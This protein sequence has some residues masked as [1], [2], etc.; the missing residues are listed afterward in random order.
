MLRRASASFE[1]PLI[2]E[3]LLDRCSPSSS[4][5]AQNALDYG[6]PP[7]TWVQRVFECK[8]LQLHDLISITDQSSVVV[9]IRTRQRELWFQAMLSLPRLENGKRRCITHEDQMEEGDHVGGERSVLG[10][11]LVKHA[12]SFSRCQLL[13]VSRIGC[14]TNQTLILLPGSSFCETLESL[15]LI[16]RL[17]AKQTRGRGRRIPSSS[18]HFRSTSSSWFLPPSAYQASLSPVCHTSGYIF[19]RF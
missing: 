17:V 7:S 4:V 8:E 19:S 12:A 13:H 11:Y 5:T 6:S 14:D 16:P 15:F 2:P 10:N 3:S 1:S 9:S 18:A